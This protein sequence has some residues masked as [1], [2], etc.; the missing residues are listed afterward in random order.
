MDVDNVVADSAQVQE[1]RV[2]SVIFIDD[3]FNVRVSASR[4]LIDA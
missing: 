1:S 4:I 3:T 2:D